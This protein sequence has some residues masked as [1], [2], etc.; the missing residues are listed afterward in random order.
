MSKTIFTR[1][2]TIV[3]AMTAATILAGCETQ[4]QKRKDGLVALYAVRNSGICG[5]GGIV[6]TVE[7]QQIDGSVRGGYVETTWYVLPGYA[8]FLSQNPA[9]A[10]KYL[11]QAGFADAAKSTSCQEKV[12]EEAKKAASGKDGEAKPAGK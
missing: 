2:L 7:K 1:T 8:A 3:L 5:T 12:S 10:T 11:Q 9:E 6:L 4:P